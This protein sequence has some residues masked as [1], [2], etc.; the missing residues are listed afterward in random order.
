MVKG[1]R[2]REWP[3]HLSTH[4]HTHWTLPTTMSVL[5]TP[6]DIHVSSVYQTHTCMQ[7]PI[8]TLCISAKKTHNKGSRTRPIISTLMPRSGIPV[9]CSRATLS[10]DSSYSHC[11]PICC[12]GNQWS[13]LAEFRTHPGSNAYPH[14]LQI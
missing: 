14:Y 9:I 12:H 8:P 3:R 7:A 13:H 11:N 4:T 10:C 2:Q 5:E 1:A 6:F